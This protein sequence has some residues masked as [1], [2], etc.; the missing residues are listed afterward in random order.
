MERRTFLKTI[1]SASLIGI[2]GCTQTKYP[3]NPTPPAGPIANSPIPTTASDYSYATMGVGDEA[4]A[5]VEYFGNWKCS[6]C[7]QFTKTHLRDLVLNYVEEGDL[8]IKFRSLV[9]IND[10]PFIGPDAPDIA[11][12]GLE[13]WNK[14]PESYWPYHEYVLTNQPP[15]KKEWGTESNLRR[16]LDGA[17]ISSSTKEDAIN[18][19]KNNDYTKLLNKTGGKAAENGIEGTPSMIIDGDVYSPLQEPQVVKSAIEGQ[20]NK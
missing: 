1:S 4:N 17:G 19:M 9:F 10:R 12:V 7:S 15:E 2:A 5:T 6:F 8:N 3:K 18:A 11:R 14:E 16:Y 20:I 13:V